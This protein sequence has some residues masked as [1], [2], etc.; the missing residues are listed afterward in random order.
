MRGAD[1]VY[2]LPHVMDLGT[3]PHA[4]GRPGRRRRARSGEG[5]T[6]ACAGPT[7][8]LNPFSLSTAEHPRMR[9]ADPPERGAVGGQPEHPRM[10]GADIAAAADWA[11]WVGT[12]PHARGRPGCGSR[13]RRGTRNTPACAGPTVYT[14]RRALDHPEHPRMRG[15][16][17]MRRPCLS[18]TA[19]TPPHARGRPQA[20]PGAGHRG[21]NTPACAGP[22]E[23]ATDDERPGKEHPRMRGA[24]SD[25]GADDVF[26]RGTPPHARGRLPGVR[27]EHAEQWNTPAC[28]GPTPR[29]RAGPGRPE[30]HPRMRGADVEMNQLIPGRV[31]TPPH[32]R[33][34][35]HDSRAVPPAGRNTPACAG[36][37]WWSGRASSRS[38]E[39]PRMRGADTS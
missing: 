18:P 35:R 5:N 33:G 1:A 17:D 25:V 21:R 3:P 32:A 36:P 7:S 38:W 26:T 15:A 9:G 23:P 14:G 34:R 30:E 16:D 39:H 24:D 6:P 37:T 27:Y 20:R 4:R 31:G 10:R 2:A 28:A 19:G 13:H 11:R 12:P 8:V 22:T 29:R